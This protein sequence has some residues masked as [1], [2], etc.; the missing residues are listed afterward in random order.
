MRIQYWIIQFTRFTLPTLSRYPSSTN[1]LDV[2]FC[3]PESRPE[4][5][6]YETERTEAKL[7][8]YMHDSLGSVEVHFS[9]RDQR[10]HPYNCEPSLHFCQQSHPRRFYTLIKRPVDHTIDTNKGNKYLVKYSIICTFTLHL[11]HWLLRSTWQ[12]TD[13]MNFDCLREHTCPQATPCR[14]KATAIRGKLP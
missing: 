6:Y 9:Y 7:Q 1:M 13:M 5:Q 12:K 10:L 14:K 8:L 4:G 11:N 3:C 2:L